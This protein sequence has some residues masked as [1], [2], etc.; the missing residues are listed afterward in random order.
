MK[1]K[2]PLYIMPDNRI[3]IAIEDTRSGRTA[4]GKQREKE[5]ERG[6]NGEARGVCR[7]ELFVLQ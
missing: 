2:S 6:R 1:C 3:G 4:E 7:V 5:G